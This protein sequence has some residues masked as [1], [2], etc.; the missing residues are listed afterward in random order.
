MKI[1]KYY[2]YRINL[3]NLLSRV[4]TNLTLN[5]QDFYF[6]SE[7][8]YNPLNMKHMTKSN[9]E[10]I[11][12][13]SHFINICHMI[14]NIDENLSLSDNYNLFSLNIAKLNQ[15]K[16]YIIELFTRL[17]EKLNLNNLIDDLEV[18]TKYLKQ[19]T[20]ELIKYYSQINIHY[21][22]KANNTK[23]EEIVLKYFVKVIDFFN[24]SIISRVSISIFAENSIE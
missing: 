10:I 18:F 4:V 13:H 7:L 2:L 14:L 21:I 12:N 20:I 17:M 8:R 5:L 15:S 11:F 1:S 16:A 3:I 23:E 22:E 6:K 24:I 19:L 9:K